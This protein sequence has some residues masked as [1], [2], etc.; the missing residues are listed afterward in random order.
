MSVTKKIRSLAGTVCR[1]ILP[2]KIYRYIRT[3]PAINRL[4]DDSIKIHEANNKI[5]LPSLC[6]CITYC[7]NL[8]CEYCTAFS[9]YR[10]GIASKV[11]LLEQY[12]A[13]STRISPDRFELAGGDPFLHPDYEEII[14][15]TKR[16]WNS[17]DIHVITNGLLLP[18]V[19]N[20]FLKK[21]ADL[22]I[23]VR[24]SLHL[25]GD[26]H[27]KFQK[28]NIARLKSLSVSCSLYDSVSTW[29]SQYPIN[30]LGLPV[31]AMCNAKRAW[32]ICCGRSCTVLEGNTIYRCNIIASGKHAFRLGQIPIQWQIFNEH[33]GASLNDSNEQIIKYLT[34]KTMK[35]CA[36]CV[37]TI[38]PKQ[39]C[40]IPTKKIQEIS[41]LLKELRKS[42]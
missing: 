18:K 32:E 2:Y 36:A 41:S 38:I 27:K 28:E 5:I 30:E 8:K 14:L 24:I 17:S 11:E 9:P 19:S 13:W 20:V 3:T 39:P 22:D 31:P 1:K 42:A 34:G 33:C 4:L 29:R 37:D 40:Q 21:L 23:F 16:I 26:D 35:E 7:C 25:P 15:E 6:S 12:N 10:S